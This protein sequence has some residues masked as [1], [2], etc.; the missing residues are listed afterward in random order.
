MRKIYF[1][2]L[3]I[4]VVTAALIIVIVLANK[5]KPAEIIQG[6]NTT[7]SEKSSNVNET[8][9]K[10]IVFPLPNDKDQDG[11]V[12]SRE[13]ELGTSDRDFDTDG[14]GLSDS[15]EIDDWKTNPTIF[16]TDKDGFGDGFE[17]I[18]GFNPA[19][20]GKL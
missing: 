1:L 8:K 7:T 20:P 14:D 2:G 16:D 17:V 13:A 9:E 11:I 6:D 4:L 10:E 5:K 3:I 18:N 15:S 19:G 12:D